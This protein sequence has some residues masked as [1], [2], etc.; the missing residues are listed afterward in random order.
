MRTWQF[1]AATAL[2]T[3]ARLVLEQ[4]AVLEAGA[5]E[6]GLV[7]PPTVRQAFEGDGAFGRAASEAAAERSVVDSIVL[8]REARLDRPDPL[9]TLGL[10]GLDP[11]T[12]LAEAEAA[13]RVGD[14][15]AAAREAGTA[16][17]AWTG[18]REGGR[19]MALTAQATLAVVVLGVL[20]V[21]R[22][23]RLNRTHA[24]RTSPD[25]GISAA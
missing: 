14:L 2:L 17:A 9:E 19:G 16:R 8:A 21:L 11:A 24:V 6:A 13:L 23:I 4:R 15:T 12:D 10:A 25:R 5:L 22:Q 18:A 1:E 3:E 20:L 7:L